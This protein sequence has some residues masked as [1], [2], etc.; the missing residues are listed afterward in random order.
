MEAS[1]K[2]GDADSKELLEALASQL[3]ELLKKQK[4]WNNP[5]HCLDTTKGLESLSVINT[6]S[7]LKDAAATLSD[8]TIDGLIGFSLG[9]DNAANDD[10]DITQEAEADVCETDSSLTS[11]MQQEGEATT[12]LSSEN[13]AITNLSEDRCHSGQNNHVAVSRCGDACHSSLESRLSTNHE[14]NSNDTNVT[15]HDE[16]ICNLLIDSEVNLF[17]KKWSAKNAKS[18]I[19]ALQLF[20]EMPS[21]DRRKRFAA[22]QLYGDSEKP[23][24]HDVLLS[25]FWA[26]G[27]NQLRNMHCFLL[28]KIIFMS[29]LGKSCSSEMKTNPNLSIMFEVYEYNNYTR[30]Y[31]GKGRSGLLQ[32]KCLI[33]M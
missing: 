25:E 12:S 3:V 23:R 22:G 4:Q 24:I 8:S 10:D 15:S 5:A 2:K 21:K 30:R 27:T 26:I 29:H 7:E 9:S 28:G 17:N 31:S 16:A 18:L 33:A 6:A 13:T 19:K 20:R 14:C 32:S 1:C 11:T